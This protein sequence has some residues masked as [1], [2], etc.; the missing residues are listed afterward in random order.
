MTYWQY[1]L[2]HAH[3]HG[4]LGLNR[5]LERR[6]FWLNYERK[7][8]RGVYECWVVTYYEVGEFPANPKVEREHRRICDEKTR[9]P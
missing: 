8:H 1:L 5:D 9:G 2:A 6:D 7:I 4:Y 3:E